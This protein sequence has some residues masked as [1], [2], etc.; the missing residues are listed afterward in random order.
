MTATTFGLLRNGA[1][2][3]RRAGGTIRMGLAAAVC[4]AA[5]AAI[6]SVPA[7]SGP[8]PGTA[9]LDGRYRGTL[10]AAFEGRDGACARL[11]AQPEL[12]VMAGRAWLEGGALGF[13]GASHAGGL[14]VLAGALDGPATLAGQIEGGRFL[15]ELRGGSCTY[16]VALARSS[17]RDGPEADGKALRQGTTR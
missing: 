5:A 7:R 11:A 1:P 6:V 3:S 14:V 16:T 17:W 13:R 15:G 9:D 10:T 12:V 4:L 2:G 8:A